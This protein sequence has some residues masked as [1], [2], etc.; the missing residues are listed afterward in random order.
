MTSNDGRK[1]R[2]PDEDKIHVGQ[3]YPLEVRMLVEELVRIKN[4]H[5]TQLAG[6]AAAKQALR[7]WDNYRTNYDFKY[8]PNLDVPTKSKT[9]YIAVLKRAIP[10]DGVASDTITAAL[11][12]DCTLDQLQ[13]WVEEK[14]KD[15]TVQISLEICKAEVI[16]G[17]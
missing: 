8:V 5:T 1:P 6:Q 10:V 4:S 13:R 17:K 3:Q 9:Q 16:N 7:I 12:G 2:R 15:S 11:C 14:T